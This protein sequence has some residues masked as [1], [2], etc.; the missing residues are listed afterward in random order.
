MADEDATARADPANGSGMP[1]TFVPMRWRDATAA[2]RWRY[3]GSYAIYD[4]DPL[5]LWAAVVMQTIVRAAIFFSVLDERGE[6]LGLFTFSRRGDAVEIGVGMR[7]D[8]TGA[9]RG[10]EFF[11]AGL[12]FAYAR[13]RP[14]RFLLTVAAFN[15]RAQRVY[16]RAGFTPIRRFRRRTHGEW[17]DHIEMQ[18]GAS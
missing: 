9:G 6:L 3:E 16:T 4:F 15:E 7:P 13:Y 8:L 12:E 5:A 18:R 10:L 14:R 11:S 1:Y 2:G 17:L